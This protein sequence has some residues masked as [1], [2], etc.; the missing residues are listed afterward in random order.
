MRMKITKM[1]MMPVVASGWTKGDKTV[2]R[3]SSALG[4][5]CRTSTGTGVTVPDGVRETCP[6]EPLRA[7]GAGL[8]NS[9]LRSLSMS[10]ARSSV[11]RPAVVLRSELIF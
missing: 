2:R 4:S 11:P 5:G 6:S 10:E 7:A 3:F 8:S 9:L 1:T